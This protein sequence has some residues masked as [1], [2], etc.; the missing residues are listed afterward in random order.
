MKFILLI[1]GFHI[2]IVG[3]VLR[4]SKP[5]NNFN[6]CIRLI[7]GLFFLHVIYKLT[8]LYFISNWLPN[9]I[10]SPMAL[11]YGPLF[12][13]LYLTAGEKQITLKA[14]LVHSIPFLFLTLLYVT[15]TYGLPE[16]S[17]EW[18]SRRLM[19]N[20][21]HHLSLSL[22]LVVYAFFTG[23]KMK[24]EPPAAPE[25]D[26]LIGQ[27][28]IIEGAWAFI[29]ALLAI[30]SFLIKLEFAFSPLALLYGTQ[31]MVSGLLFRYLLLQKRPSQ[32]EQ[33][34]LLHSR[35]SKSGLEEKTLKAYEYRLH[36]HLKTS[37]IYLKPALSLALLAKETEIPK[38]HFSQLLNVYLGRSFYQ[39]IADYRIAH[40][41]EL[42]EEAGTQFTIES[43]AYEC[44]FNSKTSFNRY[45]K[46]KTGCT[47]SD[48]REL[49]NAG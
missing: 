9:E 15:L 8:H 18:H 4:I 1:I 31:V 14:V 34:N 46:E 19:I 43:L 36:N 12:Y 7:L 45:F 39:V 48:Y 16:A 11:L 17:G 38:H 33:E 22:S 30:D 32:P 47:P 26:R 28:I 3:A 2:L 42:L 24:T 13:F 49:K 21:F 29:V 20:S 40:A 37:K 25:K 23:Y 10:G 35:Y 44:G 27:I 6:K 41:M 5:E